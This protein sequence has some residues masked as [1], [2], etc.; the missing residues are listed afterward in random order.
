MSYWKKRQRTVETLDGQIS[1]ITWLPSEGGVTHR[2][3]CSFYW[4]YRASWLTY[5]RSCKLGA[6]LDDTTVAGSLREVPG[7]GLRLRFRRSASHCIAYVILHVYHYKY[8][9]SIGPK[10][11][12]LETH[13]S[14]LCSGHCLS[15]S[16]ANLERCYHPYNLH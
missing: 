13:Y 12:G 7:D 4:R 9:E 15:R 6:L 5:K 1:E 10:G 3:P 14:Y 2:H 11:A 8:P 16:N